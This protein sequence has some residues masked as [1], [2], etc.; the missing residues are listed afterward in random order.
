MSPR[1]TMDNDGVFNKTVDMNYNQIIEVIIEKVDTLP[2]SGNKGRVV[3]LTTD[4]HFYLDD[5]T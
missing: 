1:I 5:G 2:T 4:N 3:C